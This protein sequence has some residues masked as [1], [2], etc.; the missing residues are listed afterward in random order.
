MSAYSTTNVHLN[1]AEPDEISGQILRPASPD[2]FISVQLGP[3]AVF[4]RDADQAREVAA[5]FLEMA[6]ALDA[7]NALA[8][9]LRRG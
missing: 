5:K 3:V 8:A 6:D 4:L 9:T 7:K 1:R 2:R